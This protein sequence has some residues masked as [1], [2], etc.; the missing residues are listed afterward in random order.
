MTINNTIPATSQF[1]ENIQ[2]SGSPSRLELSLTRRLSDEVEQ[3]LINFNSSYSVSREVLKKV[4]KEGWTEVQTHKKFGK[5]VS[6]R[7]KWYLKDE[8]E[9]RSIIIFGDYGSHASQI[10]KEKLQNTLGKNL[11]ISILRILILG[12]K[13]GPSK[14]CKI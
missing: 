10:I 9:H 11:C 1:K 14:I 3:G 2:R 4:D 5:C 7:G 8:L 13:C 12:N 6:I